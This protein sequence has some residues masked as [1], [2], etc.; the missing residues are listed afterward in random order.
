MIA[1][2]Q[3]EGK[4]DVEENYKVRAVGE[5]QLII[6]LVCYNLENTI[7]PPFISSEPH[8]VMQTA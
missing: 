1:Y 7:M 2:E 8:C 3:G 6:K 4:R 5:A